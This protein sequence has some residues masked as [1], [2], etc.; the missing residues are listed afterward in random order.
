MTL[1]EL[2]IV[3]VIIGILSVLA[4]TGYRKYTFQARNSEAMNFLQAIRAAQE[5]YYQSFGRYCGRPQGDL[6]PLQIA[7]DVK[8]EWGDPQPETWRHLGV[9]SPGW[10]WFQYEIRAGGPN[11]A[12]EGGVFANPPAKPWF[13]ARAHGDFLQGD[14]K[15][16]LFE[17]TSETETVFVENENH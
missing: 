15:T 5:S 6:W 10:V 9:K 17:I 12:P 16:S 4:V 13:V 14:N 8:E 3:V 11:D 2:M 7:G 1:I